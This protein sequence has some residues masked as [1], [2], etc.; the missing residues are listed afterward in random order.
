MITGIFVFVGFYFD[1]ILLVHLSWSLIKTGKMWSSIIVNI[2]TVL[3]ELPETILKRP[4]K[5]DL[6]NQMKKLDD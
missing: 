1:F 4:I 3:P 5:P 2:D 6:D